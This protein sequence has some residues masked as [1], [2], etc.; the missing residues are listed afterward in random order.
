MRV[1][2]AITSLEKSITN[3]VQENLQ[4]KVC[5]QED[6]INSDKLKMGTKLVGDMSYFRDCPPRKPGM[7]GHLS[8]DDYME[9]FYC[10]LQLLQVNAVSV[11]TQFVTTSFLASPI[12][13]F[14]CHT[15]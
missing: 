8:Q 4:C 7:N 2:V 11:L 5:Y 14:M 12:S 3:K 10:L 6:K 9:T 15:T 1:T 13:L